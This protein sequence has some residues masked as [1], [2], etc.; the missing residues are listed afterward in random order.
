MQVSKQYFCGKPPDFPLSF[1]PVIYISKVT[2][3]SQIITKKKKS[4]Q[5]L[6]SLLCKQHN[7]KFL[8]LGYMSI[9]P[10]STLDLHHTCT[11][12]FFLI[13]PYLF[14]ELTGSTTSLEFIVEYHSFQSKQAIRLRT[15][16]QNG[17]SSIL[18]NL[19]CFLTAD[20]QQ[21]GFP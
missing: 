4:Q 9:F 13:Q 1:S 6:S 19:H 16:T 17:L 2:Y 11:I 14:T 5:S 7:K 3:S 18:I 15:Q 10:H 8:I 12:H 20:Y 21:N